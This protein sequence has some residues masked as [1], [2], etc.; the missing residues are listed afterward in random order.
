[1]ALFPFHYPVPN[2]ANEEERQRAVERSGVLRRKHDPGLQGI[3]DDAVRIYRTPFAALSIIDRD[4]QWVA[5]RVGIDIEQT[6]RDQAFCAHAIQRPGE[7]LIVPN[8][9]LDPRFSGNPSVRFAPHVRFYAGMSIVDRGG[10][11]LGALCVF[12]YK[13]RDAVVDVTDLM[14][15]ARQA[16]RIVAR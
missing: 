5:A 13:P 11:A 12:D 15:L 10:Y 1:M 6:P 16:E 2:P 14:L 9:A 4:R 7:P 8:A 3:V